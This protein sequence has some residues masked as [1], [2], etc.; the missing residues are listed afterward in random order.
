MMELEDLIQPRVMMKS[1]TTSHATSR[2][3]TTP[4]TQEPAKN[5]RKRKAS[6]NSDSDSKFKQTKLKG[7]SYKLRDLKAKRKLDNGEEAIIPLGFYKD[8]KSSNKIFLVYTHAS[9][10]IEHKEV[11]WF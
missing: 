1:S 6:T 2:S 3:V 11:T 8:A 4:Q 7:S 10:K 5:S 9:L